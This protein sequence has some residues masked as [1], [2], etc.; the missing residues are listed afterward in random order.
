MAS[1]AT[2]PAHL[3]GTEAPGLVPGEPIAQFHLGDMRNLVYLVIDWE[4]RACAWVDPQADVETPLAEIAR[5]GLKLERILLTHTHFDHVLGLPELRR[6]YPELPVHFH[7]ED[8]ARIAKTLPADSA[9]YQPLSDGQR[10]P[11]GT[12]LVRA[13]HA[14]GHSRGALLYLLEGVPP[15][16]LTGDTIFIRDCGRTDLPTGSVEELFATLQRVRAEFPTEAVILPGHQ[17]SRECASTLARELAESPPF[18]CR[19][20]EELRALP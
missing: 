8:H 4:T 10:I 9:A 7:A 11:V 6:R 13:T 12:L 17:Y 20:V 14:P 2:I 3:A 19:S 5:H 15:Y 18:L 1:P 16:L